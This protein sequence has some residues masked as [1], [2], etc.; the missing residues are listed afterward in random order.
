MRLLIITSATVCGGAEAYALT[1][2]KGAAQARWETH[3]AF[4]L[5]E[6]TAFL[7]QEFWTHQVFYHPLDISEPNSRGV[8]AM[9][10]ALVRF[11]R[12]RSLLVALQPDVVLIN[13]PWADHCLGSI[14][15]CGQLRLP[16]AVMFHLLP[17]EK[18][19][20][21]RSRRQLY[22]WARGRE[23]QWLTNSEGNGRLL[24][25]LFE[26]PIHDVQVIYN[27]IQLPSPRDCTPEKRA[28]LSQAVRQELGL[29][30]NTRLLLT[31]GRLAP[32]K[33]YTDLLHDRPQTSGQAPRHPLRVGWHW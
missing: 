28:M 7:R 9:G 32:Q 31:V 14:L 16:T 23:Q 19:P 13:L 5:A 10:D 27:G 24:S 25:E 1:I 6:A 12:T 2:A 22:T 29:P 8:Q 30:G 26:M 11:Q 15:A 20:L 4:P 18:I 21:S 3:A 33:G 17:P